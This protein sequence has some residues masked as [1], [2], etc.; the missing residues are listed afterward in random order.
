ML[1]KMEKVLRSISHGGLLGIYPTPPLPGSNLY[2]LWRSYH[3]PERA[4]TSEPLVTPDSILT[5]TRA[6]ESLLKCLACSLQQHGEAIRNP[7]AT[8]DEIKKD[9][10]SK[11]ALQR[12]LFPGY[13]KLKRA[14]QLFESE[15]ESSNGHSTSKLR[16]AIIPL[17]LSLAACRLI[18]TSDN[19][20]RNVATWACGFPELCREIIKDCKTVLSID[21]TYL[22]VQGSSIPF[23]PNT[24]VAEPLFTVAHSGWSLQMRREAAILI[25]RPQTE[26]VWFN[27]AG[28][29]V[30]HAVVEGERKALENF[31][32]QPVPGWTNLSE[33]VPIP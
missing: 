16:R 33:L 12:P 1:M 25:Q 4:E 29:V 27:D 32:L 3:V 23:M 5:A 28:C 9:L 18:F 10:A 8:V 7:A 15:L 30:A 19:Q 20:E 11:S 31:E 22:E 21:D 2:H 17:R 26:A 13:K 24:T 6:T 14:L